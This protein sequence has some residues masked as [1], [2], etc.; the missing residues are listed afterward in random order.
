MNEL[1]K[2]QL[3]KCPTCDKY[4]S[5]QRHNNIYCC[6]QHGSAYR[7]QIK[8]CINRE[9]VARQKGILYNL[10]ILNKLYIKD[11]VCLDKENFYNLKIDLRSYKLISSPKNN[12]ND[13]SKW[14]EI[15]GYVINL[16]NNNYLVYEPNFFKV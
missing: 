10:K 9:E 1:E 12:S 2:I 15:H 4:F 5:P 11:F 13:S 8:N 3:Y 6:T 14:F 16:V 7:N